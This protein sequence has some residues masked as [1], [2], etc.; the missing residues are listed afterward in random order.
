LLRA[1][2][3][4]NEGRRLSFEST[5]KSTIIMSLFS[6]NLETLQDLYL[7]ELRDLYSA[8]TQLIE[9]LPKMAEAA[10]DPELKR[11]FADHLE[12]TRGHAER[13]EEI[14]EGLGEQPGGETCDAMKGLIKEGQ[15]MVSASGSDAVKDAGLIGAAQRV[16]HYEIAG[17]GTTRALAQRLGHHE[18]ADLLQETL[19]EEAEADELL[20][21]IA[22]SHVND[23]A[24][25][26]PLV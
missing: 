22:E 3:P 24:A 12:Q 21:S 14:F 7:N 10:T 4:V 16:E 25:N 1:R 8:E 23:Q 19:D 6:E 15:K 17:Y 5:A 26:T 2:T 9:A 20:S 13:L 18:A 11:A